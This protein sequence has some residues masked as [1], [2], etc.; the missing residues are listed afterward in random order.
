[1]Q[2]SSNGM[3]RIK[4]QRKH[5]VIITDILQDGDW[6]NCKLQVENIQHKYTK[7]YNK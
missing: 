2:L 5:L 6:S 4:L 3:K 7:H 1:M